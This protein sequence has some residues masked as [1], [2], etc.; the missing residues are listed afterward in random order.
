MNAANIRQIEFDA[1]IARLT[2]GACRDQRGT[3]E[4]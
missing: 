4:H 1:F 2:G 3:A